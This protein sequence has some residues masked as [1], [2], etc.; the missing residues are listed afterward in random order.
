M[1]VGGMTPPV[2]RLLHRAGQWSGAAFTITLDYD[3]RFVRRKRLTTDQRQVFVVDLAQTESLAQGDALE[4]TDGRL[5]SVVAAHEDLVEIT[6]NLVR[7]AWHIGNRHSPCQICATALLIRRDPVLERMLVGLGANL[8]P[9]VAPFTPQG[10]AY[11]PGR[12]MGH[13]HS[14]VHHHAGH[15]PGSD[16]ERNTPE[17][18]P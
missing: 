3:D 9:V 14:H 4:L 18:L 5:I 10:G 2:A 17:D 15:G 6:G 1:P 11:G 16:D 7:L 12:T 13:D 8:H